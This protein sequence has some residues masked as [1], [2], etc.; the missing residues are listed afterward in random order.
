MT[1]ICKQFVPRSD[2]D[3]ARHNFRPDLL[4]LIMSLKRDENYPV[5]KEIKKKHFKDSNSIINNVVYKFKTR[6]CVR[7]NL[8]ELLNHI[9]HA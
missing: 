4:P 6:L 3:Q 7:F 9:Q 1:N 2:P 5:G 8:E